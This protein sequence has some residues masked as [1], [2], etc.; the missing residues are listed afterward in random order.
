MRC[1]QMY[2]LLDVIVENRTLQDLNLSYNN[3]FD[4]M[5]E[6]FAASTPAE[7]L[8]HDAEVKKIEHK[9]KVAKTQV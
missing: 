2:E 1:H 9:L 6:K 8:K 4:S 3:I 7:K 5:Q